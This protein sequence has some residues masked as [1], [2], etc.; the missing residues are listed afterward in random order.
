MQLQKRA[1]M[2]TT[3]WGLRYQVN[4]SASATAARPQSSQGQ[5]LD[6]AGRLGRGAVGAGMG[7][8]VLG[9]GKARAS[10]RLRP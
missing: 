8:E 2:S 4:T 6:L 1:A 7:R 5:A 9:W 10:E 3:K